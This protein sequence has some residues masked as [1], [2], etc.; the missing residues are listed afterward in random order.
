[1]L[2]KIIFVGAVGLLTAALV[3]Q[4]KLG[5]HARVW[6]HRAEDKLESTIPAEDEIQRLKSEVKLLDKEIEAAKDALATENVEAREQASKVG[7]LA[8]QVKASRTTLNQRYEIIAAAEKDKDT[9][10]VKFGSEKMDL[11]KAK[12]VLQTM[13]KTQKAKEKNLQSE[14]TMLAVR[15]RTRKLAEQHL[16]ALQSQKS[17]LDA[18]LT[19]MEADVK[20]LKIEQVESKYQSDGTKMAEVKESIAKLKKRIAIQREKLN[21]AKK[22]D[23]ASVEGKTADEIMAELD[24]KEKGSLVGTK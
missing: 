17:E 22:Y 6:L 1:M 5:S 20:Q 8:E 4:T 24:S 16:A 10:F 13:V 3:T 11:V 23:P 18:V 14:E 19:E 2:K 7:A 15:E 12:E 9:H 21:L